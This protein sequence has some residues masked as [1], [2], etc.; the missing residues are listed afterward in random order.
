LLDVSG[1]LSATWAPD[2]TAFS[3]VNH[4]A[5]DVTESYIYDARTLQRLVLSKVILQSDPSLQRFA[6]G[7]HYWDLERWEGPQTV[8]VHFYGHTDRP[9]VICFDSSYRVTRAGSVTKLDGQ[10]SL[11]D[12]K[13]CRG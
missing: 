9:P 3:V 7:H 4:S 5:S 13:G 2:G 12:S 1:T 8:I 10:T 11:A 6:A